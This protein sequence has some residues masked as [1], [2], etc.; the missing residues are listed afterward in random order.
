MVGGMPFGI[1]L[2]AAWVDALRIDEIEVEIT[3]SMDFLESEKRD[4]PER[5]R[6][7]SVP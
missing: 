7:S 6:S 1:L 5:H 3:N 4:I 2:A